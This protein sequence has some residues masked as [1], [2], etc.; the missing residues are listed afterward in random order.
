MNAKVMGATMA[1]LVALS[2]SAETTNPW[3]HLDFQ[4]D[5][6]DFRF[7]I[8]P[9]RGGGDY[10]GAFTNA[11]ECCNRM[12][13]A[14]VTSDGPDVVNL[15]L[16]GILPGEYLNRANSKD[17]SNL[18]VLDIPPDPKAIQRCKELKRR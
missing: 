11:L 9:D 16:D 15:R 8:V 5:P 3:S 4:D 6:G 12:H 1:A 2:A 18:T 17:E 13:P 10:R 7:A 14:F